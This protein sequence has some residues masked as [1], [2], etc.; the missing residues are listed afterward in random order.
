M[1]AD[2]GALLA[3]CEKTE[4]D[5][6]SCINTLQVRGSLEGSG[7]HRLG[8]TELYWL[9]KTLKGFLVLRGLKLTPGFRIWPPSTGKRSPTD[10]L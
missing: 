10:L 6:R 5:I 9:E 1:R 2:T 7:G 8:I 4:N 3:L